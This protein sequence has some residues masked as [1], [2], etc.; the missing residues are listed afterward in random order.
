MRVRT[1]SWHYRIYRYHFSHVTRDRPSDW[2]A[3]NL[4]AY[5]RRIVYAVFVTLLLIGMAAG[6]VAFLGWM[7]YTNPL[8]WL[9]TVAVSLGIVGLVIGLDR[10][11]HWWWNRQAGAVER[12]P[13]LI[14]A[15]LRARKQRVCPLIEFVEPQ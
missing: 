1:D 6:A 12:P 10:F 3:P 15:Y 9:I 2:A 11:R 7:F 8:G 5:V 4:C 14:R 13:G